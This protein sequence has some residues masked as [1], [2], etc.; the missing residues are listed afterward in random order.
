MV[1]AND[2][3]AAN[4]TLAKKKEGI[5]DALQIQTFVSWVDVRT[6][7]TT[8]G[9]CV[10]FVSLRKALRALPPLVLPCGIPHKP[11]DAEPFVADDP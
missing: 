4:S 9:A 3:Q 7:T 5:L 10:A 11:P 2:N 1:A 6:T 8:L